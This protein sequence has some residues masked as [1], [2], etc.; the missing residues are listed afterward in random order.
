MP[1]IK[2]QSK[3]KLVGK[4]RLKDAKKWLF[5]HPQENLVSSYCK[6]YG[7]IAYI[8]EEKLME[9]GFYD[10]ILIQHYE[11]EGIEWEYRVEPTTGEMVVVP[12]ASE[13]HELYNIHGLF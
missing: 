6:R 13:E 3:K 4:G 5:N 1:K 8:A 2:R 9:L 10:E 7:V 11:K 12:K